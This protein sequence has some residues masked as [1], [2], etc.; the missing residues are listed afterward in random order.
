MTML[1][2]RVEEIFTR[3]GFMI[4]V[5]RNGKPLKDLKKEGVLG[6]F[7]FDRKLAGSKSVQDWKTDRFEKCYPGYSCN[8]LKADGTTAVGQTLLSTVRN[9]Y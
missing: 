2:T 9:T 7:Q 1:M 6:P 3:E 4:E 8:V 5:T